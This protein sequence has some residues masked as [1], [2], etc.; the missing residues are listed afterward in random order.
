MSVEASFERVCGSA[1]PLL[2][3]VF[4]HGLTG[5]A[6]QTWQCQTDESFWPIW[7]YD[8]LK[9]VAIYTLGY[10]ASLFEKWARK[11][12]DIFE[13]AGNVLEQF[14]GMGIG[15]RPT[16]IVTHSLGGLLAKI[17][18]RRSAESEDE[19][20]KAISDATRLVIY[21][22][23]PHTGASL[24]NALNV[25]PFSSKHIALL[26]DDS[27]FLYDLNSH[28]RAF[29]NSKPDLRTAVY[30]EKHKTKG[31]ALVVSRESADPGVAQVT[32][33]AVDKDH[34]SICKPVDRDD[35]VYLGVNRH[36]RKLLKEIVETSP[37][38]N[39]AFSVDD[40]SSKFEGDRRDL[41]QKLID[42]GREHEYEYANNAQNE[43]AR[44]FAKTGLFTAAREDHDILLS[45][46]E[47]RFITH[48]YHPIICKG[49]SDEEIRAA[50]QQH[51]V[52]SLAEKQLGGTKF[53]SK[54]V[55]SA[56]Y[57]LTEQCHLKWD[58]PG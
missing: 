28:Y 26:A 25:L 51:V 5:D 13:R 36:I 27:G 49:G 10:P 16:T 57:F 45:D 48:V 24:A 15:T 6:K 53:S 37:G 29:A 33:V 38:A 20:C 46:V 31:A 32:P 30:Y 19:D 8:D 21:L 47:S 34:I 55:L 23:T 1:E 56:L 17:L 40:Y 54:A 2:D 22:S 14:A 3:L 35:I 41:L 43:F 12:M 9:H 39:G 58:P 52:D 4:I 42:A 18:L 11:E 50:L 44:R 7:L